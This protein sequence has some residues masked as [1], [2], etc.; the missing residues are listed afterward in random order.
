MSLKK[1]AASVV[2]RMKRSLE[3]KKQRIEREGAPATPKEMAKQ[4]EKDSSRRRQNAIVEIRRWQ[5]NLARAFKNAK[6]CGAAER[7]L[8]A[9]ERAIKRRERREY[10]NAWSAHNNPCSG[11]YCDLSILPI[12]PNHV[13]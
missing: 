13:R 7:F 1:I 5:H 6:A 3:T 11:H 9:Q 2:S 8:K 10:L 4:A 12:R